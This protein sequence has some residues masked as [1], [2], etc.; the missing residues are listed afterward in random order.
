LTL[1]LLQMP[2]PPFFSDRL[3]ST[4]KTLIS[5]SPDKCT[6]R[7]RRT[8]HCLLLFA[9]PPRPA[10]SF[11]RPDVF[12]SSPSA[13]PLSSMVFFPP[14]EAPF[15][16]DILRAF[17]RAE[18]PHDSRYICKFPRSPL[19]ATLLS[20]RNITYPPSSFCFFFLYCLSVIV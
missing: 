12:F 16:C 14:L 10:N 3:P 20:L 17:S 11:Q 4:P 5:S 15:V 6:F 13:C 2:C 19:R 7:D 1:N 8:Y 18:P 9:F